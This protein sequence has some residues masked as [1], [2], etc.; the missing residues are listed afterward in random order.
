MVDAKPLDDV[1]RYWIAHVGVDTI[2][3]LGF[4]MGSIWF[5]EGDGLM[6]REDAIAR[7]AG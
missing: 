1:R 2:R 5:R 4:G 6:D 3:E 7:Y